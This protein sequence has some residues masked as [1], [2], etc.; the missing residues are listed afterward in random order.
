MGFGVFRSLFFSLVLVI[1]VEKCSGNLVLLFFLEIEI[2][3]LIN[4]FVMFIVY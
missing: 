3:I 4:I 2:L 1:V